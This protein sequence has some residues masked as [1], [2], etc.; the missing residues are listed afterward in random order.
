MD[1]VEL[2]PL[3]GCQNMGPYR[4]IIVMKADLFEASGK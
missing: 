3:K 1:G 4:V 2:I